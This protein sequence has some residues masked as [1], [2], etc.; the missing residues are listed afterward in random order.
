MCSLIARDYSYILL[1]LKLSQ[2]LNY[3]E[4][5]DFALLQPFLQLDVKVFLPTELLFEIL[6][7]HLCD[8]SIVCRSQLCLQLTHKLDLR[9]KLARE[10]SLLL[11]Q[12]VQLDHVLVEFLD[13]VE[14][15]CLHLQST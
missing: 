4:L 14:L 6:I 13:E 10:R 2:L 11:I 15:T 1:C 8:V 7:D 5:L 9:Y 12:L 3:L